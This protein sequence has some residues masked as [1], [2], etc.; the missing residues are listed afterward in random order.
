M[1][2]ANTSGMDGIT[3]GMFLARPDVTGTIPVALRLT[4]SDRAALLR[5]AASHNVGLEEF[6]EE[7]VRDELMHRTP[8]DFG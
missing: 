3:E 2:L 6:I 4:P 5:L 8:G 1:R 7:L